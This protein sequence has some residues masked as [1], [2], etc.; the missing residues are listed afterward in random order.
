MVTDRFNGGAGQRIYIF[1]RAAG[2][3]EGQPL[4]YRHRYYVDLSAPGFDRADPNTWVKGEPLHAEPETENTSGYIQGSIRPLENLTLNLGF[5]WEEQEIGNSGGLVAADIDD[6]YA[7]RVQLSWDPTSDG[8]SKVYASFGRY[9]ENI[10][11]DINVRS[12]GNEAICFCYNF[13]ADPSVT[14]ALPQ[15]VTGFRSSLLGGATPVDPEPQGPVHRRVP[16]S[17]TSVKWAT[18]SPSA[19]RAPTAT[20]A[21]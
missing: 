5:R 21:A 12:F 19:S 18:T 15:A 20:S 11:A 14:A 2:T 9:Y 10:P 7:P 17:A 3:I 16:V 8:A 13:S 1:N 4:V 6:N